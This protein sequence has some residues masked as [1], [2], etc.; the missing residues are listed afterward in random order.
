LDDDLTLDDVIRA[1]TDRMKSNLLIPVAI[2]L[3]VVGLYVLFTGF[4]QVDRDERA[5]VLRFGAYERLVGPGLHFK[6]PSPIETKYIVRTEK[7]FNKEFGYRTRLQA[8][9]QNKVYDAYDEEALILTG[10]LGVA[11]YAWAV[12]YRIQSPREFLFN[13]RNE[14][15]VIRDAAQAATRRVIG[16]FE[17]TE[18]ITTARKRIADEVESELQ[19]ILDSYSAGIYVVD[20]LT[21]ASEPPEPVVPAFKEVD[22]ARQDRER[23]RNEALQQQ[24]KIINQVQGTVERKLSVARGDSAAIINEAKGNARRFTEILREYREAPEVTEDRLFHETMETVLGQSERVIVVEDN[25][26]SLLPI[27]DLKKGSS[28]P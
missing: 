12:Q 26:K 20:V 28:T 4:Y 1:V 13:I 11:R 15:T 24:E 25:V 17:A 22:S 5:V 6:L 27:L 3:A 8:G 23:I 19:S 16:D 7:V 10:D 9:S 2:F 14:D 18:V 21:Q